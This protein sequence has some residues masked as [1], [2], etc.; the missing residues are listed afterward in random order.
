MA[1]DLTYVVFIVLLIVGNPVWE[2]L[3]N[4]FVVPWCTWCSSFQ[5][6]PSRTEIYR[7]NLRQDLQQSYRQSLL[8]HRRR[9]SP[10]TLFL[11]YPQRQFLETSPLIY[12]RWQFQETSLLVHHRRQFL[13][14]SPLVH[15]WRHFLRKSPLIH[16]W[17]HLLRKSPLIRRRRRHFLEKNVFYNIRR[18]LEHFVRNL[19]Q[20]VKGTK[21]CE[22]SLELSS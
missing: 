20:N 14:S 9:H 12:Y 1:E 21:I 16:H 19:E 2:F 18:N 22:I 3:V 6:A 17:R 13:E 5:S 11:I 8:V 7:E 15:H 10:G 4:F